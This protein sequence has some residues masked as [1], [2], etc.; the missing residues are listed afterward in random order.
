VLTSGTLYL[1]KITAQ[2]AGPVT[3]IV[4]NLGTV[5]ATLTSGQNLVAL[6][7]S[8]GN[9]LAVSADQTTAWGSGTG[10]KSAAISSTALTAGADYWVAILSVGTTPAAFSRG[11]GSVAPANGGLA[12][13][14]L[15]YAIN[16]TGLTAIPSTIT[17]SSNT[18]SNA[19]TIWAALS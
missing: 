19:A 5:G 3:N 16:G 17:P 4:L 14:V 12:T 10:I 1:V 15:K 2:T 9:R 6:F 13:T 7:D 18:G 11:P 8:A